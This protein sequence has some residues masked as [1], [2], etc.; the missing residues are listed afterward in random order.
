MCVTTLL[1]SRKS[2]F[3][4]FIRNKNFSLKRTTK[5]CFFNTRRNTRIKE[6]ARTSKGLSLFWLG[7]LIL[8]CIHIIYIYIHSTT[9]E[10]NVNFFQQ[11]SCFPVVTYSLCCPC[12]RRRT[13]RSR[14][15]ILM[16]F[17][18]LRRNCRAGRRSVVHISRNF[19]TILPT[20][21][22][23]DSFLLCWF[24]AYLSTLHHH[25]IWLRWDECIVSEML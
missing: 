8:F 13:R 17:H 21:L 24:F 18:L 10:R 19:N 2:F 9:A 15:A 3:F 12:R 20:L 23:M 1:S 25:H 6:C 7:G 4:F 5:K 11:F 16:T 22:R 14:S